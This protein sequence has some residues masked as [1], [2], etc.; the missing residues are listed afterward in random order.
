MTPI[1]HLI[2]SVP[3]ESA[4]EVFRKVSQSIGQHVKR[5]PDGETGRRSDWIGFVRRHLGKNPAFERDE[6]V[7][8]FQFKQWDGKVIREWPLLKI[9]D[10]TDH[11]SIQLETGYAEDAIT[12]FC[13]FEVLQTEGIIPQTVKYQACSATPHAI[14]YMYITPEDQAAFTE[15]YTAHLIDEVREI[16]GSIPH[17]KLAYQWDVCQEVLMWE[18]Y[19][20]SYQGYKDDIIRTLTKV[21]DAV[22]GSIDMGY[23]LCYGSPLDEHCVQPKDIGNLVEMAN[24]LTA[25]VSRRIDYIHMPVPKDRNDE[26]YFA[27]LADLELSADTDL[28]LGCVHHNDHEGNARK[29]DLARQQTDIAGVGSECGWGRGDPENLNSILDAHNIILNS[30]S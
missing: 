12:S 7:P 2:G 27:P 22:V 26:A 30:G 29:L 14:S 1:A 15:I 8:W 3:L 4:D 24:E 5:M 9:I 28:Y 21:G 17:H 6:N 10:G 19:F 18:G 20:K 11:S 13:Q 16:S 25:A 23:H